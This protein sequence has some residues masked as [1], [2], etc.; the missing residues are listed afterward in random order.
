MGLKDFNSYSQF[1]SKDPRNFEKRIAL[2]ST[3]GEVPM[4]E[5]VSTVEDTF[6]LS[7]SVPVIMWG[8]FDLAEP[9][10]NESFCSVVYN[11]EKMPSKKEISSAFQEEEFI[12]KIVNDRSLVKKMKFPILGMSDDSEEEFKTYGQ[13]KKSE[14]FFDKFKEKITPSSRFEILV[15]GKEPIHVQKKIINTP[16]DLD[17]NRWKHLGEAEGI[18]KKIH[19]KYSPDFYLLTLLESEGRLY[20]DSMTRDVSLSPAQSVNLYEAA[21]KKY[22]SSN[23]PSWFRKKMFDDHVKPYYVKKYYDSLLFKPTGVIDYKKY[24]A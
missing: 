4:F 2:A 19:S 24:L 16:F 8:K 17:M 1:Y 15:S 10:I 20:L 18:C 22:Y 7:K 21:Y 6:S 14:T 11:Q 13:F 23:L 5:N 9:G 12:P 3:H